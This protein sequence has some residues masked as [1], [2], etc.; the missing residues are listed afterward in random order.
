MS[1]TPRELVRR[2]LTFRKPERIPRDLWMLPWASDHYP[3]E[4]RDI[5]TRFPP[6]IVSAPDVY[7]PSRARGDIYRTGTAVDDWGCVFENRMAGVHGEIKDPV[8]PELS[9]WK[10]RLKPPYETLPTDTAAARE[11]LRR[12]CGN[13]DKFVKMGPCPRPWERMQFLRGT[14]NAMM[15]L[16]MDDPEARALLSAIHEFYL[17]E[18]EFWVTTDV[19]AVQFMDDWGSQARL[20]IS[21]AMWRGWFKPLYRE[22]C[23]LAHAHGKFIF[24]HSDGCILDILPD[25]AEIGVDALNSQLF[26]MDLAAVARAA[27]G[28][29]TFW[30]EIDRQHVLPKGPEAG[31]DAVRKVARAL[32]SPDGGIIAHMEFGAGANPA[33]VMAAFEEWEKIGLQ[34]GDF[35]HE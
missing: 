31:R 29:I 17:K 23:A 20:L 10:A 26:T 4:A 18:L 21:P 25:L 19:D 13:T 9:G 11:T 28:K 2:A 27:R 12:F 3:N 1:Q 24:M 34:L 22:Y 32:W 8:I 30:G 35:T 7:R 16:G 15:D 14:E 33:T 5:L 6:D